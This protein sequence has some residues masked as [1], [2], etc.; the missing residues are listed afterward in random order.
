MHSVFEITGTKPC[1][2]C[3]KLSD[4]GDLDHEAIMP[5][6]KLAPAL[7]IDGSG[8]CCPDCQAAEN[9]VKFGILPEFLM[10]RVAVGNDRLEHFRLPKGTR[11]GLVASSHMLPCSQD[12]PRIELDK[13]PKDA[14]DGSCLY[15]DRVIEDDI[16]MEKVIED[17]DNKIE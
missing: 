16:D 6:G 3:V 4:N 7:S 9:I 5:L 10:A 8:P 2:K 13:D 11:L 17:A 12:D 15:F 1:P 14:W